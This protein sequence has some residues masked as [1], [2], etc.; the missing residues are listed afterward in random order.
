MDS[1]CCPKLFNFPL[2]VA[3][4]AVDVVGIVSLLDARMGMKGAWEGKIRILI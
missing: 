2:F 4:A 3:A 1:V